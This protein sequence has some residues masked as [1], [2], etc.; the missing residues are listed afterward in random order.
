[1]ADA[2]SVMKKVIRKLN[3]HKEEEAVE[4]DIEVEEDLVQV[5]HLFV[6]AEVDQEADQIQEVKL[7]EEGSK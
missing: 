6:K 2:L 7:G 4:V 5:A 3:V 1:M